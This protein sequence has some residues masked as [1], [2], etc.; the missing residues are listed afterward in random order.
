MRTSR[1]A[2]GAIQELLLLSEKPAADLGQYLGQGQWDLLLCAQRKSAGRPKESFALP[3]WVWAAGHRRPV[4]ASAMRDSPQDR[5]RQL[6]ARLDSEAA[7]K[8]IDR[9]IR[10]C[11]S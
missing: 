11:R 2:P 3:Y 9:A 7:C 6:A 10:A 1:H 5:D 4:I 8:A